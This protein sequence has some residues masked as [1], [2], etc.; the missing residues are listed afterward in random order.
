MNALQTYDIV[1]PQRSVSRSSRAKS[2]SRPNSRHEL[3]RSH[4]LH[5]STQTGNS[6]SDW[7]LRRGSSR[8]SFTSDSQVKNFTSNFE[9]TIP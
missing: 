6:N 2:A 9:Q 1:Q 4:S 8:Q 3:R 7:S 5:M